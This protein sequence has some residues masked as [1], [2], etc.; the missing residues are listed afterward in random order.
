MFKTYGIL[1]SRYTWGN[2]DHG[3]LGHTPE[4]KKAESTKKLATA[5]TFIKNAKAP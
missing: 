2:H 1:T 3:R 5:S 4:E